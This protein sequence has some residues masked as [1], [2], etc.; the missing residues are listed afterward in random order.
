MPITVPGM[1][2]TVLPALTSVGCLGI[3]T[4]KLALGVSLGVVQWVSVLKVQ[5]VAAGA[6]GAGLVTFPWLV[7]VPAL[8]PPLLAAF[9]SQS[10]LGVFSPLMA[11]GLAEGIGTGLLTGLI[12]V[13]VP[14][15]GSGA[16][17]ATFKGTA[18]PAMISGFAQAG[19]TGQGAV[20]Q[21][22]A[23]GQGLDSF[24]S[25]FSLPVPVVGPAGPAPGTA[26][27]VGQIV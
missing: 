10:L 5:V 3:G 16:G 7:P 27:A 23:I 8:V 26:F 12:F 19:L 4:P 14:G 13:P 21:A 20:R 18:V 11:T 17:V 25:V 6:A 1:M 15:V 9:A 22:T 24:F 2:A